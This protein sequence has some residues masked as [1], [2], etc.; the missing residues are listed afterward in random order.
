MAAFCTECGSQI[1]SAEVFCQQCGSRI[2]PRAE[3]LIGK[4]EGDGDRPTTVQGGDEVSVRRLPYWVTRGTFKVSS[5]SAYVVFTF[6]RPNSW[7]GFEHPSLIREGEDHYSVTCRFEMRHVN[8]IMTAHLKDLYDC[9]Y[10]SEDN[11][12]RLAEENEDRPGLR[13]NDHKLDGLLVGDNEDEFIN[14]AIDYEIDWENSGYEWEILSSLHNGLLEGHKQI[15]DYYPSLPTWDYTPSHGDLHLEM[16][17]GEESWEALGGTVYLESWTVEELINDDKPNNNAQEET[18][19][20]QCLDQEVGDLLPSYVFS[21][22]EKQPYAPLVRSHLRECPR[23]Q[24][25]LEA[26]ALSKNSDIMVDIAPLLTNDQHAVWISRCVDEMSYAEI[27][28]EYGVSQ[29]TCRL[30]FNEAIERIHGWSMGRRD[31]PS[32]AVAPTSQAPKA[33]QPARRAQDLLSSHT[34][35]TQQAQTE[36]KPSSSATNP[37]AQKTRPINQKGIVKREMTADRRPSPIKVLLVVAM[38]IG[39]SSQ[40]YS[41]L[42][43]HTGLE[44]SPK[45]QG[46]DVSTSGIRQLGG[47]SEIAGSRTNPPDDQNPPAQETTSPDEDIP[48]PPKLKDEA[49]T[50]EAQPDADGVYGDDIDQSAVPKKVSEPNYPRKLKSAAIEGDVEVVFVVNEKGKVEDSTIAITS[51]TNEAFNESVVQYIR[52]LRFNPAI[53]KGQQVRQKLK[54]AFEFRLQM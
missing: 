32:S 4:E 20:H 49:I 47:G 17:E 30:L 9:E 51:S 31:K 21:T 8:F 11:S 13:L 46:D 19:A 52:K 41:K 16:L 1:E 12:F 35:G 18:Q 14:L 39:F 43:S 23:C 45:V 38:V 3:Q 36:T 54:Q 6:H 25:T 33:D 2:Q 40:I 7:D 53:H 37:A 27:E 24:L 10:N 15:T 29:N 22:A 26:L 5:K 48:Q 28:A 42:Q 34:E 50:R 44:N